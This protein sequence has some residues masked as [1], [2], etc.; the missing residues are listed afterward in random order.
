MQP[1]DNLID[2]GGSNHGVLS[3]RPPEHLHD[4]VESD[5]AALD[6]TD[7]QADVQE[8]RPGP[9]GEGFGRGSRGGGD[10]R[11]RGFAAPGVE[12]ALLQF[13]GLVPVIGA[14]API[15]LVPTK[16]LATT[17]G[18]AKIVS[19]SIARVS[20][21]EDPAV[22]TAGQAPAQPRPYSQY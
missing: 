22:P 17:E 14:A 9:R 7:Q 4:L 12:E 19:T 20:E 3:H 21:K 11:D 15:G 13:A 2:P 18:T 5:G 8:D 1:G 16:G 10:R 6:E